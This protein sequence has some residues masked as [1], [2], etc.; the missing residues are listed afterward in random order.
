[1]RI[2]MSLNLAGRRA[3]IGNTLFLG[4][5]P[6]NLQVNPFR[7]GTNPINEKPSHL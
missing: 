1:M 5:F 4:I 2:M 6:N 7:M 3:K